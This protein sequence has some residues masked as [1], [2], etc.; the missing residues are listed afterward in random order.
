MVIG[1]RP[2]CVGSAVHGLGSCT[3]CCGRACNLPLA[4]L[5]EGSGA[6]DVVSER[7][8]FDTCGGILARRDSAVGA[9]EWRAD[10]GAVKAPDDREDVGEGE[11]EDL[12]LE[13]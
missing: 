1:N 9:L 5:D 7:S 12:I 10:E 3:C 11:S 8:L 2:F 13:D 6:A 4:L